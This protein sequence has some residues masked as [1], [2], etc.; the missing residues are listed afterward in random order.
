MNKIY[1]NSKDAFKIKINGASYY[2]RLLKFALDTG[3]VFKL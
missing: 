2:S 3:E 1:Q